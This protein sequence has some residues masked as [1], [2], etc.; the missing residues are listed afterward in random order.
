[1]KLSIVIVNYNVKYFLHQAL[2]A[3]Y[4]SKVDF[5][6]EV[7]VVDNAS[8]DGSVEMVSQNFPQVN[9][10][11]SDKNLGFSR[12]NNLAIRQSKASYVLLLNPDTII[13]ED[14]LQ[15]VVSFM[16]LHQDAGA[17]GV[18]MY[19]GQGHFLPESK[20][21]FPSPEVAFYK[22]S[23]L[24]SIFPKSSIFGRYYL[25]F[26]DADSIHEVDVLAG[27][28]MLLRKT[29]LDKVG[30]LDEDYFMYGED[31]DLSYRIKKAGFKNFYFP[32]SPII[33]FKGESTKKGSLNYVMVF[34]QA[35]IIFAQ[36]HLRNKG[37]RWYIFL[38]QLA[39]YL[40]AGLALIDR[41]IQKV[42]LPLLD[43]AWI[44]ST[45]WTLSWLWEHVI[46]KVD[47]LHFQ[48]THYFVN[49]PMYVGIWMAVNYLSGVYEQ[50]VKLFQIVV[51]MLVGTILIGTVYGF[52]PNELRSSRG[53]ILA[54]FALSTLW[55]CLYR[56]VGAWRRNRWRNLFYTRQNL[57]VVATY[58]ESI[59]II[60][61]LENISVK[62]NFIGFISP[63]KKD[64]SHKNCL[65]SVDK[66]EEILSFTQA[67]EM[68]FSAMDLSS[69]D[70]ISNI[71]SLRKEINFKIATE[72]GDVII[73][74]DSKDTPGELLTFDIGYNINKKHLLRS[75]RFGDIMTSVVLLFFSPILIWIQKSKISFL[76][77]LFLVL[78][79][80]KT[81]VSY[82]KIEHSKMKLPRLNPGVL[83]PM[84]N[85]FL[86]KGEPYHDDLVDRQ[87]YLYA[88]NYSFLTD[89]QIIFNSINRLGGGV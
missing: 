61:L 65:G 64:M 3:V 81:W 63:N 46:R 28:F 88:K 70:I 34:Y 20:R 50:S 36:K 29:V 22:M 14:T 17:L 60:N 40:R 66:I 77:N 67:D 38:L 73:G 74:S 11:V 37:G 12:G 82:K 26:L 51:A 5:D 62:R 76:K 71:V 72:D 75:K 33:H 57:I 21:G 53:I 7:Y 49:L 86:E 31:I 45:F 85:L 39:I 41:F 13:R 89:M 87:N 18:K 42:G 79:G 23:G 78:I 55:M 84:D 32:D 16:D 35:M 6:Y 47:E 44:G 68:I 9:L 52:F 2:S 1:M 69:L 48:S 4:K 54:T 27:A 25:G 80:K 15:K 24:S 56:L 59:R 19:D 83:S 43:I 58:E 10:I 8:V 30:L